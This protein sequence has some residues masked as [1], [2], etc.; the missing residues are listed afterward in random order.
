MG[1][2]LRG[3]EV[4]LFGEEKPPSGEFGGV[5]RPELPQTEQPKL[6]QSQLAVNQSRL[7]FNDEKRLFAELDFFPCYLAWLKCLTFD[8]K[9]PPRR[10]PYTAMC[11]TP[12]LIKG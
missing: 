2:R 5:F 10:T 3:N 8:G 12:C 9:R 7:A 1:S 6:S 4:R 11:N